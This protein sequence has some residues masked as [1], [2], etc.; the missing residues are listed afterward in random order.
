MRIHMLHRFVIELVAL[1]A[2]LL[3]RQNRCP[4]IRCRGRAEDIGKLIRGIDLHLA[5]N[6]R[7]N[8][9]MAVTAGPGRLCAQK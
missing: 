8:I 4:D 5:L 3:R 9:R 7:I 1:F 2:H 6:L